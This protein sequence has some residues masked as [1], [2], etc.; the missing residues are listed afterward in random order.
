MCGAR[1]LDLNMHAT[2]IARTLRAYLKVVCG[3]VALLA[4]TLLACFPYFKARTLHH[5]T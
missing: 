1:Q 5:L 2:L 4:F 3:V